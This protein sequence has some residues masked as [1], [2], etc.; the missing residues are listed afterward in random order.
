[1][2]AHR[3]DPVFANNV[4]KFDYSGNGEVNVVDIQ[5]LFALREE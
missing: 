5:R 2:F 3:N 4:E 1:M